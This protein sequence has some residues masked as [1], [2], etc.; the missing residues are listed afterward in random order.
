MAELPESD[1]IGATKVKLDIG[2][3]L[4]P[5]M[6]G[7]L[8]ADKQSD[9]VQIKI[10]GYQSNMSAKV[11]EQGEPFEALLRKIEEKAKAVLV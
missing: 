10:S 4:S 6:L 7:I 2:R 1:I 11:F 5:M 9:E 3:Q 8:A